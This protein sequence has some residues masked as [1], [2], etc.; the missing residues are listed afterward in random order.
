MSFEDLLGLFWANH[1][2]T[3][4]KPGRQYINAL[5]YRDE[6]QKRAAEASRDATAESLG[7]EP[8]KIETEIIPIRTFTYAEDYHHKYYLTQYPK[9]RTFLTATY[10]T[11][12]ELADS[13]VATR[14][15]GFLFSGIDADPERLAEELGSYDLP[16]E[17]EKA[18]R[19]TLKR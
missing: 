12:K 7:V 18:I 14:L 4:N 19:E 5:F 11:E 15:N 2:P 6:A 10:P 16:E 9:L 3:R 8:R 17:I 1:S 13:T